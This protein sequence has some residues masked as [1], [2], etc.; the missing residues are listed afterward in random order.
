MIDAPCANCGLGTL[1]IAVIICVALLIGVSF[2]SMSG[3]K[4]LQR[5]KYRHAVDALTVN[6]G[7][8]ICVELRRLVS[9]AEFGRSLERLKADWAAIK[10]MLLESVE[11]LQDTAEADDRQRMAEAGLALQTFIYLFERRM[12]M[13]Q[14]DTASP[15]ANDALKASL[16]EQAGKLSDLLCDHMS[17]L[18]EKTREADEA[19]DSKFALLLW[20]ATGV[21]LLVAWL[22]L[23][24]IG[25]ARGIYRSIEL[26]GE[27]VTGLHL[28]E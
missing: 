4:E 7:I 21:V 9:D 19:Y 13:L 2:F 10:R 26:G 27:T 18:H 17:V 8:D 20:L 23:R 5:D 1:E 22:T 28:R 14:S 11:N 15:K 24:T 6:D 3:L 12:S 25:E 16:D